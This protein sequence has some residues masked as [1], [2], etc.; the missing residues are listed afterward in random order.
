MAATFRIPCTGIRT[1]PTSPVSPPRPERGTPML[2]W[3]PMTSGVC[4][5]P[6]RLRWDTDGWRRH[7]FRQ[8][9]KDGGA[10][11]EGRTAGNDQP[12]V[13]GQGPPPRADHVRGRYHRDCGLGRENRPD[14]PVAKGVTVRGFCRPNRAGADRR[15]SGRPPDSPEFDRAKLVAQQN[16]VVVGGDILGRSQ[17]VGLENPSQT[18]SKSGKSTGTGQNAVCFEAVLY[19]DVRFERGPL[20]TAI[21]C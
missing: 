4:C 18:R 14:P 12:R 16:G 10:A 3:P 19:V 7:Q 6:A 13:S 5:T 9:T 8:R 15:P 20:L 1:R 17:P 2:Q 11:P 21:S